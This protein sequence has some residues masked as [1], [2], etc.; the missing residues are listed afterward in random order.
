MLVISGPR[1]LRENCLYSKFSGPYSPALGLNT[2]TF[3]AVTGIPFVTERRNKE[4]KI[5]YQ[6]NPYYVTNK[7]LRI[8]D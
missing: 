5:K 1:R 6:D 2:G 3:H 8:K 4:S 7:L